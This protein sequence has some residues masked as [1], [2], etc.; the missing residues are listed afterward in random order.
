MYRLKGNG[1][2]KFKIIEA[3]IKLK[4]IKY[5]TEEYQ[6]V[7]LITRENVFS[8]VPTIILY[9][10]S[11]YPVPELIS[12]TPIERAQLCQAATFIHQLPSEANGLA[13]NANPFVFGSKLTL[14]DILVWAYTTDKSYKAFMDGVINAKN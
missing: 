12:G 14:I 9:L 1:C 8:N 4:G 6:N 11:R 13:K 5:K 3:I 2:V 10:D 7:E